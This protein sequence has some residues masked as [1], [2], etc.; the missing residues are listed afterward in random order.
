[1]K[2][3]EDKRRAPVRLIL[4]YLLLTIAFL[5]FVGAN[6]CINQFGQLPFDQ[7]VF[8]LKVPL[9]GANLDMI[10]DFFLKCLPPALVLAFLCLLLVIR[11]RHTQG[12]LTVSLFGRERTFGVFPFRFLRRHFILLAVLV[13]VVSLANGA[14]VLAV[15]QYVESQMSRST[16]FEDN[17]VDPETA[18]LTFP[19]TKRNLIY[20]FLESMETSYTSVENGGNEPVDIM[21]ELTSLALNNISFSNTDKLGGA[22]EAPGVTWTVAAMTA[23]TAGV[24]LKIPF[25]NNSY[26]VNS[27]SFLPGAFTI[28]DILEREGYNQMLL[29]GSDAEFGGRRQ[30]FTQH[31][32]YDIWD[33]NTAKQD[34][35]IAQ[36]YYVWWGY[37]DAKL[38][39]YAKEQLSALASEPEPFNFTMLT[40]DTHYEDGYVCPLCRDDYGDQYANVIACSSRQVSEFIDWIQ[41]QDFYWNT[42]IVLAGDHLSMGNRFFQ[43]YGDYTRTTYN[44]FIN[45]VNWTDATHNRLFSTM[46]LYPTTLAAMGVE[47]EGDRLGLGTNLFSDRPTLMEE[48]GVDA[49]RQELDKTSRFYNE[50][51]LYARKDKEE[52]SSQPPVSSAPEEESQPEEESSVP[53]SAVSDGYGWYVP[54]Y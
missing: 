44:C 8:H 35:K 40:V 21:P 18:T 50:E 47:I 28:G 33:Y 2:H 45:A 13:L 15:P 51:L 12:R 41:Q 22:L 17:Y 7:I 27:A 19:Q 23:Q 6:W 31:G 14:V 3:M 48:M 53:E 42:T 24:P 1:M 5:L 39:E 16:I 43:N 49:F 32:N 11:W 9:E 30:L 37:E 38:F 26:G 4:G 20:I 29:I 36:D 34:G 46:D 52:S 10:G 25:S 54:A